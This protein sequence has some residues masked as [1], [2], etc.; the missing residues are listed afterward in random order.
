[1]PP[2]SI[3][4][5]DSET[6]THMI[7]GLRSPEAHSTPWLSIRA[8]MLAHNFTPATQLW[9]S[10]VIQRHHRAIND[11]Q[12]LFEGIQVGSTHDFRS[13]ELRYGDKTSVLRAIADVTR[14]MATKM[15]S[16]L[17]EYDPRIGYRAPP[18]TDGLALP[19]L[20]FQPTTMVRPLWRDPGSPP[21]GDDRK[22]C[23]L[24]GEAFHEKSPPMWAGGNIQ[25]VHPEC[26]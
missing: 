1:M 2:F 8:H 15:G 21:Q 9:M 11:R 25:W 13:S 24:C 19:S 18:Y 20:I 17:Y 6:L 7:E 22:P 14:H 26:W 10:F 4:I 12:V 16:L 5:L 3:D 23:P